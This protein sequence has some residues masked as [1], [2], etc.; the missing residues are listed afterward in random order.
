VN[1]SKS[2][3]ATRSD[4]ARQTIDSSRVA[5]PSQPL[6]VVL[7]LDVSA[8]PVRASIAEPSDA[9]RECVGWL[10]LI[11]ALESLGEEPREP[12]EQARNGEAR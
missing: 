12:A 11:G 5:G 4:T 1:P 8:R 10:A 2:L 6:R 7:E 9:R 3:V